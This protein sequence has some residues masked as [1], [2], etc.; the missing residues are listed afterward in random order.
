MCVFIH[1]HIRP[2]EYPK[3]QSFEIASYQISIFA[4]FWNI[5]ISRRDKHQQLFNKA[6]NKRIGFIKWMEML[7]IYCQLNYPLKWIIII[8]FETSLTKYSWHV[9]VVDSFCFFFHDFSFFPLP[10]SNLSFK[11]F[12]SP[13]ILT[14]HTEWEQKKRKKIYIHLTY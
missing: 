1:I 2:S 3:N 6:I 13:P 8:I 4:A 14:F 12:R 7:K 11:W 10:I 5:Q 9:A